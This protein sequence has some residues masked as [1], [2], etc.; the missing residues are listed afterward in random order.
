MALPPSD[1]AVK[2]IA[3]C[4]SPAVAVKDVGADG[5]VDGV[6]ETDAEAELSPLALT[7]FR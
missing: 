6:T 7:A 5:V 3:A 4:P 2:L 1:P